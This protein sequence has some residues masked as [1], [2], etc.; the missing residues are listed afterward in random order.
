MSQV[1][2]QTIQK[3]DYSLHLFDTKK[4]KTN[5][6][7]LKFTRPLKREN[8]TE[9]ALLPFVLQKGSEKYPTERALRQQLDELYGA[10]F[11]IYGGKKGENHIVTFILDIPNEKFIK[12]EET[13]TKEGLQFLSE[14][15]TK[16]KAKNQAFDE[17]LV[18]K[19]KDTLKSKIQSII[20]EKM[21]YA[22][23]RLIDEMCEDEAFGIHAHGYLDDL[24]QLDGKSLYETYQQ[25]ITEDRLDVYVVGD[26]DNDQMEKDIEEN[27]SFS[28]NPQASIYRS[29]SILPKKVETITEKQKIQQAK[30]HM[31]F[32]TGVQFADDN[33]PALQVFNG[34]FGGYPHSK[35]F[36]NVREKHSL[37]YYAA[38]RFESNKGLLFVFSG[39]APDKYDQAREIIEAQHQAISEGEITDK[40]IDQTKKAITNQLKETLDRSTGIIDL[41]HQQVIGGK[42]EDPQ[43]IAKA[44]QSVTKEDV[45]AVSKQIELDT[46]YF[47][48]AENGGEEA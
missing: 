19:E 21:Q 10:K 23:M 22:N 36:L 6:I 25:M 11:S 5:T 2:E 42:S 7:V 46:V 26:F 43:A 18:E 38:S 27:L 35:L 44:I 47:L 28:R 34:I 4:F 12:D 13:L 20:D 3:D 39:I 30:L 45:I 15:L 1:T 31:G 33:F 16:P 9:R 41:F 40:E 14:V 8:I 37:A 24:P 17:T 48:T 29:E 32:R